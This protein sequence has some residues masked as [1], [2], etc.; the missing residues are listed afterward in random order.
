MDSLFRTKMAHGKLHKDLCLTLPLLS[1]LSLQNNLNIL[2][3]V[4][5]DFRVI[6]VL[7]NLLLKAT[8]EGLLFW[9]QWMTMII[10]LTNLVFW[11]STSSLLLYVVVKIHSH[12]L[13]SAAL[14]YVFLELGGW[15]EC[16]F[17]LPYSVLI[18]TLPYSN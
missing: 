17:F 8:F 18:L 1:L 4:I 14:W 3:R 12:L 5:K 7:W 2:C 10:L 11:L 13:G 9:W 6:C 16:P 15:W